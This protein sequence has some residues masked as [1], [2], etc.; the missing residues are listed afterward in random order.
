MYGLRGVSCLFS[1][2]LSSGHKDSS[3]R[4]AWVPEE[5][6]PPPSTPTED[7]GLGL[8]GEALP[9]QRSCCGVTPVGLAG[10][11]PQ[12]LLELCSLLAQTVKNPPQCGRSGFDPWVGKIPWRRAWPP[13]PVFLPG[14]SPWT[15]E[16]VG[17]SSRGQKEPDTTER[18]S[19]AQKLSR[20]LWEA[21]HRERH[22]PQNHPGV[23]ASQS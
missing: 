5:E 20:G 22:S 10:N 21:A 17:Y 14:E 16:P 7:Q 18:L 4:G 19:T 3:L 11:P 12:N 13:P 9:W 2:A 23:G 6:D 8:V 15:E 1:L